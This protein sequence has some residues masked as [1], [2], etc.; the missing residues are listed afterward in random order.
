MQPAKSTISPHIHQPSL[1]IMIFFTCLF[2]VCC[3]AKKSPQKLQGLLFNYDC[4]DMF[5]YNPPDKISGQVVD[6]QIDLFAKA[7]VTV[8][9]CNTN[10]QRANYNSLAFEPFWSGYDPQG[11]DDQPFLFDMA[12]QSRAHYRKMVESMLA[13]NRQGVDYPARVIARC[14]YNKI[15]PWISL[16]MNDIHNN[17]EL[18]HPIHSS[19][20]KNH[21]E[22]WRVSDRKIDYYDR[23]LDYSHESVRN[24]Y[25]GLIRETLERYDIDG[26]ELDF[27][28]EP[29]LFKPGHELAGGKILNEWLVQVHA[30]VTQAE[31][32]R[33]HAIKVG[34]RVPANPITAQNLGLDA[35]LWAQQGLIDLVVVT[36]RWASMDTRMPLQTWKQLLAAYPITLAGGLEIREQAYPDGPARITDTETAAGAAVS[37]LSSGAD[38]VYLFNYFSTTGKTV[39]AWSTDAYVKTLRAMSSLADLERLPRRR[40]I[41]TFRDVFAPGEAADY[42]LPA[43]GVRLSFRMPTGPKPVGRKTLAAIGIADS[44]NKKIELR[45]NGDSCSLVQKNENSFVFLVAEK[46]LQDQVQVLEVSEQEGKTVTVHRVELEMQNNQMH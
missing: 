32:K 3:P 12:P 42:P 44:D 9:M 35:V 13:L 46:S 18:Q 41:V 10:A 14:R 39:P 45:V 8:F 5:F 20:W 7:G 17:D 34:V 21:H 1:F 37:V 36:P 26:L 38:A 33:G 15:S 23:A 16:R 29:Y 43:A 40:H 31:Q 2:I 4:T 25:M 19:F 27:M 24:R 11:A 30:H 22:C 6:E 28:R